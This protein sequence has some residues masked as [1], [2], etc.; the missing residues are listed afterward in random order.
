M[1]RIIDNGLNSIRVGLEDYEQ[2]Y[3]VDDDAR[4]TSAVR[5]VYAGILLLAKGKLCE[6]SPTDTPDILIRVVRPKLVNG[7]VEIVPVGRRTIGYEEIKQHFED[8]ALPLDW[9]KIERVRAIRNDLEH[10]YYKGARASVQEALAGAATAIRSLLTLLRLDPVR[11]LGERWWRVLLK[12]EELFDQELAMCRDTFARIDWIN[13]VAKAASN[14]FSCGQC[15]SLLIRQADAGNKV[16][17]DI[18]VN[19]AACGTESEMRALMERAVERQ[20]Y[21]DLYEFHSQGGEPPVVRCPECRLYTLVLEDIECAV[22]GNCLDCSTAW[23][24]ICHNPISADE[25]RTNMHQ[26]PAFFQD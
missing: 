16:Q 11:H 6:L 21:K 1:K 15:G 12:N 22:C 17:D 20:Y 26:C 7:S 18:H 19:C 25:Q 8:S 13:P 5:N 2:A 14:H 9:V 23:C 4:L 24:E 3:Q 10:F